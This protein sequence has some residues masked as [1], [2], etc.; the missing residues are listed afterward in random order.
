MLCISNYVSNNLTKLQDITV[1][2][3]KTL[4]GFFLKTLFF[5][6]G[7]RTILTPQTGQHQ[8]VLLIALI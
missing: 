1:C 8:F 2:F 5:Y 7:S 4:K 6:N 3:S